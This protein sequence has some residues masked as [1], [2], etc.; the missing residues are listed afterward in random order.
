MTSDWLESTLPASLKE[1]PAKDMFNAEETGYF[2]AAC[3]NKTLSF[4]CLQSSSGKK[5]KER[6]TVMVGCNADGS[7]K[8]PLC[9]I[10]ESLN[11]HCF[12]NVKKLPVEYTANR[13]AWKTSSIFLTGCRH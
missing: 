3:P 7:E 10:G 8:L 5:S 12:K 6:V 2:I 9:A 13:K 1:C 4:K 11:P